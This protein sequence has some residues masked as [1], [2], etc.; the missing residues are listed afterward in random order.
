[1][2]SFFFEYRDKCTNVNTEKTLAHQPC[3]NA[4]YKFKENVSHKVIGSFTL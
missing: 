3:M 1:M 2:P 4:I